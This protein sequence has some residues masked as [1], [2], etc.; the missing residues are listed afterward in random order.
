MKSVPETEAEVMNGAIARHIGLLRKAKQLSFDEL[1][2][3]SSVSKGMLVQ[4]EQGRA[5]PSIATLC[6]VAAALRV[7]VAD[8]IGAGTDAAKPV[9]LVAAHEARILWTGAK[10]GSASL[11][12]GARGPDMLE[13]WQ[14]VLFPGERFEA[15]PH[16]AGTTELIH[17]RVGT[18]ALSVEDTTHRVSAG[19]CAVANTD[20]VHA[21][22]CGGRG[23]TEFTMVV[24]ERAPD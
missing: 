18:L 17:V 5:N 11:L 14:W 10:G 9:E 1:A 16:G 2:A 12:V 19:H 3:R 6:R 4:I 15:R 23:R 7:S 24:S 13:L 22:E 8:L 21:Y 20:R